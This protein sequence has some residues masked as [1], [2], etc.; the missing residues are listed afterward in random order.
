MHNELWGGWIVLLFPPRAQLKRFACSIMNVRRERLWILT[1]D[2]RA[3]SSLPS[4]ED[5]SEL[6]P[7]WIHAFTGKGSH[8]PTQ[9][10]DTHIRVSLTKQFNKPFSLTRKWNKNGTIESAAATHHCSIDCNSTLRLFSYFYFFVLLLF[11]V[12]RESAGTYIN[13]KCVKIRKWILACAWP[14]PAFN[15]PY[16]PMATFGSR[17]RDTKRSSRLDPAS[18]MALMFIGDGEVVRVWI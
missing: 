5:I 8:T 6:P 14:Y 15:L 3:L 4:S 17:Q 16:R 2:T 9:C 12:W 1:A 13:V 10:I 18:L 7:L 11:S